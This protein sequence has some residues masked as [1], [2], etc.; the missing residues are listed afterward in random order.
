MDK[1][2][3]P[4]LVR[5]R[6][7]DFID[8]KVGN[9]SSKPFKSSASLGKAI[10][11]SSAQLTNMRANQQYVSMKMVYGL[12]KVFGEEID[13]MSVLFGSKDKPSNYGMKLPAN[14]LIVEK[15]AVDSVIGVLEMAN[16]NLKKMKR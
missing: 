1:D 15:E 4:T 9:S 5:Q 2:Y 6:F 8:S 3:N 16:Y 7:L 12:E 10:G 11:I 14:C 13:I